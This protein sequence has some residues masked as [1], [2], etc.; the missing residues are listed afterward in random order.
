MTSQELFNRVT[1]IIK[2][3]WAS[4]MLKPCAAH[5]RTMGDKQMAL[6]EELEKQGSW[7]FKGRSYLPLFILLVL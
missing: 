2:K 3:G 4:F 6:G 1:E 5:C 7:L